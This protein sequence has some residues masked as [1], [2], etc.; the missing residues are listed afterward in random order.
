MIASAI[1]QT[2]LLLS[3]GAFNALLSPAS[4]SVEKQLFVSSVVLIVGCAQGFIL[5]VFKVVLRFCT[6]IDLKFGSSY[7]FAPLTSALKHGVNDRPG[8]TDTTIPIVV[9]ATPRLYQNPV[10]DIE[11]EDENEPVASH[12]IPE[13]ELVMDER[14][15]IYR[16]VYLLGLAAFTATY[17]IDTVSP[18]P[19]TS[20][21]SGLLV[22]SI[23]QSVNILFILARAN[24]PGI[25]ST[26][27]QSMLHGKRILT[28]TSCLFASV[29]FVMFCIGLA[30]TATE[31]SA[32]E[33]MFDVTFS[34]VLPMICPWLLVTV[35]PK[36][37][38]MR[39]LMECTPFVL[40]LCLA[41]ILFFLATRGQISTII[42]ALREIGDNSTLVDLNSMTDFEI[43]S[44]VNA[45]IYFT[46]DMFS[47]T[48]V[49]SAGNIPLLMIAP[50]LKIPTIVVVLANVINRSNLLV[51]NS[52]LIVTAARQISDTPI[53][54]PAYRAYCVTLG[55][56]VFALLF[57]VA[58][59]TPFPH[60][61]FKRTLSSDDAAPTPPPPL[62]IHVKDPSS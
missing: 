12:F 14:R 61:L 23:A 50:L 10:L 43:H 6:G 57:N 1:I 17:C 15:N 41:Y 7:L 18:T 3:S 34:I 20:F 9:R 55:L 54:E 19:A 48:S 29:A 36:Q 59:Y 16:D 53:E 37:L 47:K 42:H 49:D 39:T 11:S 4:L 25:S 46:T 45:S 27:I 30:G 44:D 35:S 52:L 26:E 56:S 33:N 58:K 62:E 40:T 51:I 31:I 24:T 8:E 22:L 38:P 28:V 32:V 13:Q 60:T 2:G 21:L 5:L